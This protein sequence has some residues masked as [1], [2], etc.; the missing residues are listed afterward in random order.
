MLENSILVMK[1]F[2]AR[3]LFFVEER[4][5]CRFDGENGGEKMGDFVN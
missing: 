4:V 2:V 1:E 5:D 3:V